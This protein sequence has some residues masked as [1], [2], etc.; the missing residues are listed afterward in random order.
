MKKKQLI[1]FV[2]LILLAVTAFHLSG[3]EA[4]F[5]DDGLIAGEA[6]SHGCSVCQPGNHSVGVERAQI[7]FTENAGSLFS[8]ENLALRITEPLRFIFHPPI[9][10]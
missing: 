10:L 5:C 8:L 4:A 1:K 2:F 7:T 6:S 3:A 9:S